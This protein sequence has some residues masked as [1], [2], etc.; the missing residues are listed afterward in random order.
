MA[1]PSQ[2]PLL[3]LPW[4][5]LCRGLGP[6]GEGEVGPKEA[7]WEKRKKELAFGVP[8]ENGAAE[9]S[10]LRTSV[11]RATLGWKREEILRRKGEG[12][13]RGGRRR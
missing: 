6:G 11:T 2:N 9:A 7:T 5:H 12:P 10:A 8:L 1:D 4:R 3:P 13:S